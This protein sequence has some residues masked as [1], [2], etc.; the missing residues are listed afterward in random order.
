MM[1]K[2]N[3]AG[4]VPSIQNDTEISDNQRMA[5]R[6]RHTYNIELSKTVLRILAAEDTQDQTEWDAALT[7]TGGEKVD[8]SS[9]PPKPPFST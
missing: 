4:D 8:T 6:I 7:R 9:V 5:L 3:N 2:S 1:T